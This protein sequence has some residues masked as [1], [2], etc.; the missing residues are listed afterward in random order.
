MTLAPSPVHSDYRQNNSLDQKNTPTMWTQH[1]SF[2]VP[3]ITNNNK[4]PKMH[5]APATTTN[6]CNQLNSVLSVP[7]N[8][9]HDPT[10]GLLLLL[11]PANNANDRTW[12][13]ITAFTPKARPPPPPLHFLFPNNSDNLKMKP[14]MSPVTNP[15]MK[16]L[17]LLFPSTIGTNGKKMTQMMASISTITSDTDD[18]GD[19]SDNGNT[20]DAYI[21]CKIETSDSTNNNKGTHTPSQPSSLHVINTLTFSLFSSLVPNNNEQSH[22]NISITM[23]TSTTTMATIT[24]METTPTQCIS[25]H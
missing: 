6:T 18:E 24:T 9:V 2:L 10:I 5:L 19:D 11:P 20:I 16:P 23:A 1:A 8:N 22:G 4:G 3:P 13:L 12:L 21:N 7:V 14:E 17:S 15:M 25:T